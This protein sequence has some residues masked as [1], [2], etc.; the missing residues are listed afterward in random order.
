MPL[1]VGG[2]DEDK[3]F[4]AMPTAVARGLKL[5]QFVVTRS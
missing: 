1:V 2:R 4:S 5:T 3:V